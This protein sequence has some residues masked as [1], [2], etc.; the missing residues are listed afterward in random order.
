MD[1]A[2]SV[3]DHGPGDHQGLGTINIEV[4]HV[5]FAN[6]STKRKFDT[7]RDGDTTVSERQ[8]KGGTVSHSVK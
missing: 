1:F 8:I 7:F 5:R 6:A 4:C 3:T 2:D